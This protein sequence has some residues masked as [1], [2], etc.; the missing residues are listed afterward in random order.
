MFAGTVAGAGCLN[1]QIP[2]AFPARRFYLCPL[3]Q[4]ANPVL[5]PRARHASRRS[6]SCP[7]ALSSQQTLFAKT[8]A[9]TG[10]APRMARPLKAAADPPPALAPRPP[11]DTDRRA[12]PADNAP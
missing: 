8:L 1:L 11:A 3:T 9:S 7:V 10:Q 6:Q 12:I 5:K 4:S 2:L